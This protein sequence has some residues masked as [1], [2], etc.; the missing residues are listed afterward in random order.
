MSTTAAIETGAGLTIRC[1]LCT[2]D[3]AWPV[4]DQQRYAQRGWRRPAT[5]PVCQQWRQRPRARRGC[6]PGLRSALEQAHA[7]L[8]LVGDPLAETITAALAQNDERVCTAVHRLLQ[9]WDAGEAAR[10]PR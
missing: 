5:C 2:K 3:F 6:P 1:R 7:T 9:V 4:E 10:D 8:F